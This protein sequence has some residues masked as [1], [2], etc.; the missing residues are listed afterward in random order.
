MAECGA[1][2][3]AGA[4][5]RAA[6]S[7]GSGTAPG[8]EQ[9]PQ[10]RPRDSQPRSGLR[11]GWFGAPRSSAS[12]TGSP[13]SVAEVD[14]SKSHS[15][16]QPGCDSPVPAQAPSSP[17]GF[18]ARPAPGV[19]CGLRFPPQLLFPGF[20]SLGT[21]QSSE[22]IFIPPW[23]EHVKPI[24]RA[25][26][27]KHPCAR[28]WAACPLSPQCPRSVPTASPPPGQAAA[29]VRVCGGPVR[30]L[31]G[32]TR[33]R[34]RRPVLLS[35]CREV[36]PPLP[37]CLQSPFPAPCRIFQVPAASQHTTEQTQQ[38]FREWIPQIAPREEPSGSHS[39]GEMS[40]SISAPRP[41]R[42][43]PTQSL[44]QRVYHSCP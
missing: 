44:P 18:T 13:W 31:L 41:G 33:L 4:T 25:G 1:G 6:G 3:A 16:W 38:S 39:H 27:C 20:R 28:C 42:G 2:R 21:I 26:V 32:N 23:L 19:T 35:P 43:G 9:E 17:A 7:P 8:R 11:S 22:W 14:G 10:H 29:R 40:G 34:C 12:P 24:S 37:R 30:V 15:L 36:T 5:G